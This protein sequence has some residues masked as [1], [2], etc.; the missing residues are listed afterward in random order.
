[1]R[2]TIHGI[3]GFARLG[4]HCWGDGSGIVRSPDHLA[5]HCAANLTMRKGAGIVSGTVCSLA[6]RATM[7][8]STA[9]P[10][11]AWRRP[12]T[13]RH[14]A[15]ATTPATAAVARSM[16]SA[17]AGSSTEPARGPDGRA[18]MESV[19]RPHLFDGRVAVVTG[20]GTGIGSAIVREL[21]ALDCQVVIASRNADKLKKAADDFNSGAFGHFKH[22]IVPVT[23]NIRKEDEVKELFSSVVAEKGRLDYLVNNGGGQFPSPASNVALKGWNAVIETNLTGTFLCCREAFSA[24]MGEHGGSVVNIVADMW[25]G[26]P[27]MV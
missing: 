2:C 15:S 22:D 6:Q 18:I 8:S 26:F 20:G 9:S 13:Q 19:F 1:M 24:Y 17:G 12:A 4:H 27:M 5:S 3:R 23:C 16:C 7:V 25:T 10:A 14:A 21:A 11:S